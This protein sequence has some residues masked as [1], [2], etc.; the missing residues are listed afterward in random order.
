M[1]SQQITTN[2]SSPIW[3]WGALVKTIYSI[4]HHETIMVRKF[5]LPFPSGY[6]VR[7]HRIG[8]NNRPFYLIG[9]MP[10]KVSVGNKRN[11][12]PDEVIGSVDPMP[13]EHGEL[14]VSCDLTRLCYYLGK[15]ARLS[16]LL[17]HYLGLVGFYP[18]HP[19][20]YINA[21]RARAGLET[22]GGVRPTVHP[23]AME[24]QN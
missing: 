22:K 6:S 14:I 16:K 1:F 5:K 15:E 17:A 20:V 18:M 3:V 8:C 10:K 24:Q 4:P 23:V 12:R 7:L 21:W 11:Q 13:N 2:T 9:A 19:K